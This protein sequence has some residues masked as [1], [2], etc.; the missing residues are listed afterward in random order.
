MTSAEAAVQAKLMDLCRLLADNVLIHDV[1]CI[2]IYN[3]T[4][5]DLFKVP[6]SSAL[7]HLLKIPNA[8]S[9]LEELREYLQHK[10]YDKC[11][12]GFFDIGRAIFWRVQ[13]LSSY[14]V[15]SSAPENN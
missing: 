12:L 3:E 13:F 10:G 1:V 11:V 4:G 15:P 5:Q 8:D 14:R 2:G 9:V 6:G 7:A